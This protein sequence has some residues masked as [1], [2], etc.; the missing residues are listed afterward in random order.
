LRLLNKDRMKSPAPSTN[1]LTDAGHRWWLFRH[2]SLWFGGAL[3]ALFIATLLVARLFAPHR[4]DAS[5]DS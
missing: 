4:P 2:L 5:S 3:M 1:G